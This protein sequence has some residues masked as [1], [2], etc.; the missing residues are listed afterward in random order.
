[1]LLAVISSCNLASN[2]RM[3]RE[4][5]NSKNNSAVFSR[6]SAKKP[7]GTGKRRSNWGDQGV[8]FVECPD[9]GDNHGMDKNPLF[10]RSSTS[11]YIMSILWE[12][13]HPN[14]SVSVYFL[15]DYLP[16]FGEITVFW[17]LFQ[18]H[19]LE[20][21]I[22]CILIRQFLQKESIRAHIGLRLAPDICSRLC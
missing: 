15:S 12:I 7:S 1:V 3:G 10:P 16:Y 2:S 14:A 9:P 19:V 11:C 4:S 5:A 13:C 17:G 8:C 18:N 22:W 21:V 6:I 20:F